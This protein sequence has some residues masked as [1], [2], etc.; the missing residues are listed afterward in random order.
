MNGAPGMAQVSVRGW[1]GDVKASGIF[2][3]SRHLLD[4]TTEAVE[5]ALEEVLFQPDGGE[6][7]EI[8][9]TVTP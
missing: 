2:P 9:I 8:R 6:T 3:K 1:G 4:A 5:R 7:F